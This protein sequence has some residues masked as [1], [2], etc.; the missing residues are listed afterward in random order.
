M[1]QLLRSTDYAAATHEL[2]RY[3]LGATSAPPLLSPHVPPPCSSYTM[4]K[5]STIDNNNENGLSCP[6]WYV[7]R[8]RSA[9][10]LRHLNDNVLVLLSTNLDAPSVPCASNSSVHPPILF[11]ATAR[12][13]AARGT[14]TAVAYPASLTTFVSCSDHHNENGMRECYYCDAPYVSAVASSV[15]LNIFCS[16]CGVRNLGS[17][18]KCVSCDHTLISKFDAIKHEWSDTTNFVARDLGL[19]VKVKCP[20]CMKVCTV[21]SSACFRCGA[22]HVYFA[23]PSVG[24]V[25]SFHVSRLTRSLSSSVMSLFGKDK[26]TDVAM[27][28]EQEEKRSRRGGLASSFMS[29]FRQDSSDSEDD[30]DDDL[31]GPPPPLALA[32]HRSM[33]IMN[34]WSSSSSTMAAVDSSIPVGIR[35]PAPGDSMA[36]PPSPPPR[37]TQPP[38]SP[39]HDESAFIL[40]PA[41]RDMSYLPPPPLASLR[42][43]KSVPVSMHTTQR[44][45]HEWDLRTQALS[46]SL[47]LIGHNDDEEEKEELDDQDILDTL[48]LSNQSAKQHPSGFDVPNAETIDF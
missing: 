40:K 11:T 4:V 45:E 16:R 36:M 14:A 21:P 1:P 46:A 13:A 7:C 12:G 39:R 31:F 3:T 44:F 37:R 29:L 15:P 30:S 17:A 35:L 23:A 26:P 27:P 24:D 6:T 25:T 5:P 47:V 41:Y 32:K 20:G 48:R 2:E 33:D 22:C 10:S 38:P 19:H 43:S 28:E 18:G 34:P 42:K 9:N 8:P